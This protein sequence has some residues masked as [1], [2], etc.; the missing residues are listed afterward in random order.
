MPKLCL[1]VV[2]GAVLPVVTAAQGSIAIDH[3]GVDCIVAGKFP[4]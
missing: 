2:G 1:G 4:R 3:K